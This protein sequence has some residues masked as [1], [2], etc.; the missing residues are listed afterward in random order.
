[1]REILLADWLTSQPNKPIGIDSIWFGFQLFVF[2]ST[3]S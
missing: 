2:A 3:A 1:M